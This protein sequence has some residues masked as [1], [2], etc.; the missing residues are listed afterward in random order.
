MRLF[1]IAQNLLLKMLEKKRDK[2]IDLNSICLSR[3][4][5]GNYKKHSQLHSKAESSTKGESLGGKSDTLLEINCPQHK[6][7]S[8]KPKISCFG[9]NSEK[10]LGMDDI[11]E[12]EIICRNYCIQPRFLESF[13]LIECS[14]HNIPIIS[15]HSPG[16]SYGDTHSPGINSP[17]I[18]SPEFEHSSSELRNQFEPKAKKAKLGMNCSIT[19]H[20][21]PSPFFNFDG[22]GSSLYLGVI[23]KINQKRYIKSII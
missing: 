7:I 9:K 19:D 14:G 17:G 13:F 12:G 16:I 1:S 20:M 4:F 3:W 11:N 2:R 6:K 8:T 21:H 15:N 23:N 22:N 18:N 5:L 10:D